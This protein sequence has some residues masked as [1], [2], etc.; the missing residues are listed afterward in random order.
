[1][2]EQE[3]TKNC[4]QSWDV[5]TIFLANRISVVEYWFQT[6]FQIH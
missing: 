2:H 3:S 4:G 6:G 5:N 1:V